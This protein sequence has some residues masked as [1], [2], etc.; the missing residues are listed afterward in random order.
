MINKPLIF[1]VLCAAFAVAHAEPVVGSTAGAWVNPLP[2]TATTTGEGSSFFT[3]GTPSASTPANSLTFTGGAFSSATETKFKV[4]TVAYYNGSTNN[5]I[6]S[7]ALSLTL[8]FG[9]PALGPIVS[10]YV[11]NVITTTNTSDPVASADYLDLPSGF[12]ATSFDI[13]GTTY[14]V[15]LLDFENIVGDGFLTSTPLQLHV[16]EGG[17]A[18]ADLF[19]IVTTNTG[20]PEPQSLGLVL[21]GFGAMGLTMRRRSRVG[22]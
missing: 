21:A 22:A 2:G 8:N 1:A 13:D 14:N 20:V 19:A 7:V 4:G 12:S 3:W 10:N 16:E 6:D 5:N 11:F 15:Q 18:S 9:N 17:S